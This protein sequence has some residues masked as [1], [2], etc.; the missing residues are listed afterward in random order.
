MEEYPK[1]M[2]R[3]WV[4]VSA[5]IFVVGIAAAVMLL[6]GVTGGDLNDVAG[7][8]SNPPGSQQGAGV[9]TI[10]PSKDT[11]V[12]PKPSLP[13]FSEK[14]CGPLHIAGLTFECLN[15]H[16]QSTES[17]TSP[18]PQAPATA[19]VTVVNVYAWWCQP[20]KKELPLF[21]EFVRERPDVAVLAIH[22]DKKSGAG[23]E[24]IRELAPHLPAY[25]DPDG[26]L[27][28]QLQLPGVI[29]QT[30]LID[31]QGHIIARHLG[32][33]T[34]GAALKSFIDQAH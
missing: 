8:G 27:S 32:E 13:P 6:G 20:C 17:A 15:G 14:D 10:D 9:I 2:L 3:K 19:P 18:R 24:I 29:P 33:F 31:A 16:P 25:A 22:E 26:T 21:E 1:T 11:S 28:A 23:A 34:D 5:V 12:V 30:L 4:A 7:R